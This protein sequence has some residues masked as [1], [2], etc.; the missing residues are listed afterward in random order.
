MNYH[1]IVSAVKYFLFARH[2]KGHGIHSPFVFDIINTVLRKKIPPEVREII[3]KLRKEMGNSEEIVKINDLGAGSVYNPCCHRRLS[4]IAL[5]SSVN[6]RY[7]KVLYNLA[8]LY[9]GKDILELG[10]S[11]GVSTLFLALGAPASKIISIEGSEV[12]AGIAA[13][14]FA[15]YNVQNINLKTG[16]FT[17]NLQDLRKAGFKASL[18]FVDGDH[19]KE[20]LLRNFDI[21]KKILKSGSVMIFDD[22]NYS[23]DMNKAWHEIKK[24]S[25]VSVSIDIFQMGIVFFRRGMVKQDFKIRY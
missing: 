12:L 6:N 24:D 22:I 10:T 5:R 3:F 7:G 17:R 4:D 20:P 9:D 14:N 2:R 16:E 21:L 19:R 15:R 11:I 25:G 1:R 8:R 23:S 13:D 18:I